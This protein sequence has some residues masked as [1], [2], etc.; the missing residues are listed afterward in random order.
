[1]T[2]TAPTSVTTTVGPTTPAAAPRTTAAGALRSRLRSWRW[3]VAG[4]L[5]LLLAVLVTSVL[6]P[7]R[8]LTRFAPDNPE[9]TG[10][11]ALAQVLMDQGVDVTYTRSVAE[12]IGA[13]GPGTTLLVANDYGMAD[14]VARSLLETGATIALVAP[15][16]TLLAAA[17][18]EVAHAQQS[19]DA[20]PTTA[21]CT[22][23]DARAAGTLTSR[24][25]GLEAS[26]ASD[27][28]SSSAPVLCFTSDAGASHYAVFTSQVLP[29]DE[30]ASTGPVVRAL[31]DA[32]PLTNEQITTDGAATL[33]L[34][35]LGHEDE[36]VWLIPDRPVAAAEGGGMGDLLPP[37]AGVLFLQLVVLGIVCALWRGRRLGPLVAEDLPVTV[38]SSETA[39]GRGRLYRRARA[40]GHAAAAL[41]AG[42]AHRM[43][44]RL[45]V[46]RSAG[47]PTMID[48]VSRATDRPTEQVAGLL[49]GPPP[50]DDADL[51]RLAIELDQLESE[52]HRA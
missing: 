33:G 24:G 3:P 25:G 26:D 45:G 20:T 44:A 37:W 15:G 50:A 38:P 52:V 7:E 34:R 43:A 14:D 5:A 30:S 2:T 32:G 16:A 18:S 12:A 13:A 49:Y 39:L 51:A 19:P 29:A 42:A 40:W 22:D 23:P 10:G 31:D 35:M 36:L 4:M 9:P 11:Q 48:A 46:P 21:G 17:T 8:S 28:A 6:T 47:A 27:D 1:M 41:R